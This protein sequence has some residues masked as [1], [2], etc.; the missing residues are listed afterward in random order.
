[1]AKLGNL[2]WYK[3]PLGIAGVVAFLLLVNSD[4]LIP[5]IFSGGLIAVEIFFGLTRP[6]IYQQLDHKNPDLD[7]FLEKMASEYTTTSE[8]EAH[9]KITG[10]E[11]AAVPKESG[12]DDVNMPNMVGIT[13]VKEV[14]KL[15]EYKFTPICMLTT[16]AEQSKLVP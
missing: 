16:E 8:R 12:D 15:P 11:V 7:H 9:R 4:S 10:V 1:M 13:L 3:I 14:T 2:T 5:T 6:Q